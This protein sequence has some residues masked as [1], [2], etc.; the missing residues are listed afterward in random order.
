MPSAKPSRSLPYDISADLAYLAV[1]IGC[2]PP[3]K[4]LIARR[5]AGGTYGSSDNK[6]RVTP[7]GHERSIPLRSDV[8]HQS[9]SVKVLSG[10]NR[11]TLEGHS[12]T[13]SLTGIIIQSIDDKQSKNPK[14]IYVREDVVSVPSPFFVDRSLGSPLAQLTSLV[15]YE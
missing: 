11:A 9:H 6:Y 15:R 5:H 8:S 12:S 3:F 2:L 4:L 10:R 14:K 7:Y 1:I 13:E